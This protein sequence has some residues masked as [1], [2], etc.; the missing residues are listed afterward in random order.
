MSRT[1]RVA[2]RVLQPSLQR[3]SFR[4]NSGIVHDCGENDVPTAAIVDLVW[5]YGTCG[6]GGG[7]DFRFD[8]DVVV[9]IDSGL[10][11]DGGL[12]TAVSYLVWIYG[13]CGGGFLF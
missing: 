1:D 11:E 8:V 4:C 6:G 12:T 9:E 5:I 10:W 13:E 3:R 2:L 7:F